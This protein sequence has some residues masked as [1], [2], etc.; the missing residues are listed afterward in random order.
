MSEKIETYNS[1][2]EEQESPER[3]RERKLLRGALGGLLA[4][5]VMVGGLGVALTG[6]RRSQKEMAKAILK[7]EAVQ[8]TEDAEKLLNNERIYSML[9]YAVEELSKDSENHQDYADS[10]D[11]LKGDSRV[12]NVYADAEGH[13]RPYPEEQ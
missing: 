9:L 13:L 10:E 5:S 1:M 4:L 2:V 8:A 11:G 3:S 12:H 6:E 7:Q